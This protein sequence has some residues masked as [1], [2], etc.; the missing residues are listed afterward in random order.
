MKDMHLDEYELLEAIGSGSFGVIRKVRRKSDGKILARKEIDYRKMSTYEKEQLIAEVNILQDL[1]HPN[2]VEFLMSAIDRDNCFIYILMEY[3]EGGDLAAVIRRHRENRLPIPEEFVWELM[4]QLILALH[5][6]HYG[7][8]IDATTKKATP[9]PILHRDLKPDNVFLDSKKNVKLGDFGLSRT[10]NNPQ[11]AFAQTYVGELINSSQ[12]DARADI[13]SLGC[14]VFEM[15]ALQPPFL[16]DDMAGLGARIKNG[17]VKS[18]PSLYSRELN[19]IVKGML[20]VDVGDTGQQPR[21]RPTTKDLL[22]VPKIMTIGMQLELRMKSLDLDRI[23]ISLKEKDTRLVNKENELYN[24]EQRLREA[25]QTLREKETVIGERLRKREQYLLQLEQKLNQERAALDDRQRLIAQEKEQLNAMR[26]SSSRPIYMPVKSHGGHKESDIYTDLNFNHRPGTAPAEMQQQQ[27]QPQQHQQQQQRQ[28]FGMPGKQSL[29]PASSWLT[30]ATTTG[31]TSRRKTGLTV[32]RFSLQPSTSLRMDTRDTSSNHSHTQS[33]DVGGSTKL[34]EEF[35]NAKNNNENNV[36]NNISSSNNNS[37][38]GKE[39]FATPTTTITG[40]SMSNPS[41]TITSTSSSMS[42]PPPSTSS[43]TATT[44]TL[45]S[46]T[47]GQRLSAPVSRLGARGL[48][49]RSRLQSKSA[50]TLTTF[51]PSTS[52]S[53][54]STTLSSNSASFAANPFL[55]PTTLSTTP[56]T[57]PPSRPDA[58][59]TQMAEAIQTTNGTTPFIYPSTTY[60]STSRLSTKMNHPQTGTA[61]ALPQSSN[62]ATS[63]SPLQ[64]LDNTRTIPSK[65]DWDPDLELPSPFIKNRFSKRMP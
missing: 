5:E 34:G 63:S 49:A 27:Q 48:T 12:Y 58:V 35:T 52:T 37:V 20:Q 26:E 33:M 4:T 53:T 61:S 46:T 39:S 41:T 38:F 21:R 44:S 2:I 13:W 65:N 24:K 56:S 59:D 25:E 14:V 17:S 30:S 16:A 11:K 32:G 54:S 43:A 40:T 18:L 8:T 60:S 10:L 47:N 36:N 29:F 28:S 62:D 42:T 50:S 9:R 19:A 57:T 7:V 55:I 51:Q 15:C 6:C 64:S 3:C 45:I 23:S 1:K 31:T 22:A